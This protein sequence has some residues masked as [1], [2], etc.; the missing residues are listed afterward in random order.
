MVRSDLLIVEDEPADALLLQR[1]FA[2][3][4]PSLTIQSVSD[5][6][7][8]VEAIGLVVEAMAPLERYPRC[9]L[10]DLKLRALDGLD[11]LRVIK[12]QER[13]RPIPVII[14]TS[15][16]DPEDVRRAYLLGANS[17]LI[18]PVRAADLKIMA[19]AIHTYWLSV[20]HYMS[21]DRAT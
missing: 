15:S 1:A 7:E 11:V 4:D 5:G 9:I 8:A 6:T 21:A 20:N 14:L 17:Y 18:K 3:I 10:L 19:A 12:S 13:T 2:R 16:S